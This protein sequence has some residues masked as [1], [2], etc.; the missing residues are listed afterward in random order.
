[1]IEYEIPFVCL[2]FT[3]MIS[4]IFFS[5]KKIEL[6]ENY[7]FKNILIFTLLVNITTYF[8]LKKVNMIESLKSIE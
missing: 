4:I 2:I 1:M 3:T 5:K 6:E 8:A 7:Y